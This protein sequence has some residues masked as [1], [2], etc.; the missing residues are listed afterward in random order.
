M[1]GFHKQ[2]FRYSTKIDE[3]ELN[4]EITKNNG[5]ILT[6]HNED[7]SYSLEFPKNLYSIPRKIRAKETA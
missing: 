7:W 1:V 5:E 6:V 4:H 3:A 2:Q